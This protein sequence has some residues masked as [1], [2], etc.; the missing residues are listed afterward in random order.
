MGNDVVEFGR[1]VAYRFEVTADGNGFV[2]VLL[3]KSVVELL[4]VII[5]YCIA[6]EMVAL[7]RESG[8]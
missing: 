6:V 7:I 3:F 2:P 8:V 5:P 4:E 1:L